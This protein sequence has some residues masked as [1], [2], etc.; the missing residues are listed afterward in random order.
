MTKFQTILTK[1]TLMPIELMDFVISPL[2]IEDWSFFNH[3]GL[4]ISHWKFK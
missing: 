2:G 1:E 4:G 3:Y